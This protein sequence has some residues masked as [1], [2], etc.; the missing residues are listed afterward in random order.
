MDNS[1]AGTI[2]HSHFNGHFARLRIK[3]EYVACYFRASVPYSSV[4]ALIWQHL[5]IS[6]VSKL[7]ASALTQYMASYKVRALL[8]SLGGGGGLFG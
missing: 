4:R 5:I 6:L 1:V 8:F 2:F 7:G 3:V